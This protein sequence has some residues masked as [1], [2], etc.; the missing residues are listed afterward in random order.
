MAY[1]RKN[2]SLKV[3]I[4]KELNVKLY[5]YHTNN[6]HCIYREVHNNFKENKMDI[7]V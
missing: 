4:I 2:I 1:M 7:M 5:E 3:Q 6:F